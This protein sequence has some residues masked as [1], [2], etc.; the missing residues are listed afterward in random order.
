M[1]A[2]ASHLDDVR[3]EREQRIVFAV[4]PGALLT[5]FAVAR[6]ASVT[7]DFGAA[8]PA[9]GIPRTGIPLG[10]PIDGGGLGFGGSA[11]QPR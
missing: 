4:R 1:V 3:D 5:N 7:V 2:V 6:L 10:N 11:D 8:A 9:A